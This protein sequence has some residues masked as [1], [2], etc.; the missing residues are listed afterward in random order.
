MNRTT[1]VTLLVA[2]LAVLAFLVFFPFGRGMDL[3]DGLNL[4][5]WKTIHKAVELGPRSVSFRL[6]VGNIVAFVPLG[7]LLPTALRIR[8]PIV[9]VAIAALGGFLLSI[10]IE[11]TQYAISQSVGYSYRST[12]IDDV[13]LNVTGALIGAAALVVVQQT[14][15]LASMGRSE[16]S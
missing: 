3:G 14:R 5:L 10:G 16:S 9:V 11:A 2:Y 13:V 8:N 1:A 4:H 7:M 12:D 15:R 6:M